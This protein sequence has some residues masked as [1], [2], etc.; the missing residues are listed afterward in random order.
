MTKIWYCIECC[1]VGVEKYF[2]SKEELLES[3]P[4]LKNAEWLIDS[5][6]VE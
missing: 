1:A 6:E 3:H 2:D 5:K 4:T